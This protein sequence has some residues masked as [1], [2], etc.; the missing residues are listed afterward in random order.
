MNRVTDLEA[1][2][3]RLES[4]T[5]EVEGLQSQLISVKN[6]LFSE[7]KR[8]TKLEVQ[9]RELL[10]RLQKE[11]YVLEMNS[12][13][14]G[15][16]NNSIQSQKSTVGECIALRRQVQVLTKQITQLEDTNARLA[17][18]KTSEVCNLTM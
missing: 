4:N 5:T 14:V 2:H 15:S 17:L 6:R 16:S 12:S 8:S 9:C 10:S 13:A 1:A 7:E 11:N 3:A 18:L